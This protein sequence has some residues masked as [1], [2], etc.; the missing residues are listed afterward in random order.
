MAGLMLGR[1]LIKPGQQSRRLA[2]LREAKA[3][4]PL[5]IGAGMMTFMAAFIEAYWSP[6][7]YPLYI[8]VSVGLV[9]WTAFILY[10]CFAGR[11]RSVA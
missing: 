4:V 6:L 11:G 2:L 7:P 1:A 10:F 9:I 8:K 3:S 5:I